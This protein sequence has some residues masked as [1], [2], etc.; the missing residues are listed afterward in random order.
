MFCPCITE[1]MHFLACHITVIT[2]CPLAK[3]IPHSLDSTTKFCISYNIILGTSLMVQ[4]LRPSPTP[5]AVGLGLIPGQETRFHMP[6]LRDPH[7]ATK[8]DDSTCQS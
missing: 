4:W 5:N 6:Q 7:A 2:S 3:E 1:A 8:I